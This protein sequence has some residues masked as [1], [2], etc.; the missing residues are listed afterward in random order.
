VWAERAF[1]KGTIW[2]GSKCILISKCSRKKISRPKN[3]KVTFDLTQFQEH[4]Y[5]RNYI[6]ITPM[7]PWSESVTLPPDSL[8]IISNCLPT[9]L[10]HEY[11]SYRQILF[12]RN[13]AWCFLI[14]YPR[15]LISFKQNTRNR[16][17]N[18][19]P[20][21]VTFLPSNRKLLSNMVQYDE[22]SQ[23]INWW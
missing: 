9:S 8:W 15:S 2:L 4:P 16:W 6:D 1:V 3:Q 5:R 19:T 17:T 14:S 20:S 22:R 13:M 12:L 11:V 10:W 23:D 18:G 7:L 21:L